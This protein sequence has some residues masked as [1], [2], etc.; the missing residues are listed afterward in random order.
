[1]AIA[2]IV[3]NT[4]GIGLGW[5]YCFMATALGS[6]VPPIALSIYS[7]KLDSVFAILSAVVGMI[8]ALVCWIIHASTFEGGV[9][10][11]NL[12]QGPAQLTGGV[13]ALGLSGI[14]CAIGSLVKPMNFDWNILQEG[15]TLVGGDG[16]EN[17][18]VLGDDVDG[19]PEALLAAKKWIWKY[20]IGYSIFLVVLWPL[21]FVP[22]GTFGKSTS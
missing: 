11:G 7:N 10:K 13:V 2:S 8:G 20:G 9:N 17:A 12:G 16:G 21:A 4:F 18:K 6:A 22:M 19:T 5:V 14:I 3:L 1:M 15:V